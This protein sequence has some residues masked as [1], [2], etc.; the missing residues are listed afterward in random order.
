MSRGSS[1]WLSEAALAALRTSPRVSLKTLKP[2]INTKP[3]LTV[4][5]HKQGGGKRGWSKNGKDMESRQARF[6][7]PIGFEWCYTPMAY[8][9]QKEPQYN[10]GYSAKRQY[11]PL[12]LKTL[13][14]LIDTERIDPSRPIDLA[15]LCNTHTFPFNPMLQQ[16]GFN[17]TDE[18]ADCFKAKV[19]L[20]VQ[21]ANE[22]A[23][24]AVERNGGVITTAYFDIL[25]VKALASPKDWFSEGKPV[26]RRLTPPQ[27]CIGF[28][29]SPE[30]RGYLADPRA[31]AEHRKVLGQK[32][33]YE[34]PSVDEE[35]LKETKDPRQVFYGL[36]AGWVVDLK[37]KA[38]YKPADPA[39][40]EYYQT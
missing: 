14:L 13:Q 10:Y 18:G 21:W 12:S 39:L 6:A 15:A 36:Q 38:I 27:D 26:P 37:D 1:K 31:V 29:S 28:Y 5:R 23:I 16:F 19:N 11:P 40:K 9:I 7:A 4:P 35:W 25:S 22:Q 24:A 3:S 20:E 17:L 33:G 34:T 32:Y 8:R 2:P 30:N